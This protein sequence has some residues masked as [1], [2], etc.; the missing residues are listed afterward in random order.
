MLKNTPHMRSVNRKGSRKPGRS[1]EAAPTEPLFGKERADV[2][3]SAGRAVKASMT[4]AATH[5]GRQRAA[6]PDESPIEKAAAPKGP[7]SR[8]DRHFNDR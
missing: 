1:V 8:P 6:T 2:G 4:P 3:D 7:F 5:R